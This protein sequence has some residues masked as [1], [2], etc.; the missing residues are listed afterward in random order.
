[1]QTTAISQTQPAV[2]PVQ[3]ARRGL[4]LYFAILIPITAL[5]EGIMILRGQFEPWV[6][7]LMF[8]P[9]LASVIARLTLREG[10]SDVSFRVGGRRGVQAILLA[11]ILP[12]IVGVIAYGVAWS[13]GLA[14]FTPP[15]SSTFPAVT[16]PLARLGLQFVS[17]L[18]VGFL[19]ALVLAAGEE[20]GWRGYML[21]RL[22]DARVPQPVLV[23]GLIWG[24]WHLPLI[25]SGL[26]AAGPNP[27]LSALWFL[28]AITV[29]SF[30]YARLRLAT[31]SIWPVIMLHGAWNSTIQ[32][33][34]D[35]ST[36]GERATVW[37]GESGI[38]VMLTIIIVVVLLTRVWRPAA[39]NS[40]RELT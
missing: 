25:L 27:L 37:V 39:E 28:V 34:F 5:L 23:S 18:N 38:L 12:V 19:I 6:I 9:T 31:G 22:I 2:E 40:A 35:G 26:Y 33:V 15:D 36:S 20:I 24:I 30:L 29:S 17:V 10:F 14:E 1:M 13:V 8:T 4:L 11:L 7:L 3:K 21:T 32:S 16:N